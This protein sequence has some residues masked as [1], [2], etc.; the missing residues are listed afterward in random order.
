MNPRRYEL[1]RLRVVDHTAIAAGQA[2]RCPAR[3]RPQGPEW[4][5][6]A[7]AHRLALGRHS[8]ALRTAHHLRQ[9]VSALGKDRGLG[10]Y[11]RGDIEGL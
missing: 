6:L 11:L 10:P 9:P 4:D 2:A 1:K 3:G 8:G 7:P 5:L